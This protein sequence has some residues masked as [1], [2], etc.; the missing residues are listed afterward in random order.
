MLYLCANVFRTMFS[1]V[2]LDVLM[3]PKACLVRKKGGLPYGTDDSGGSKR[4]ETQTE[5]PF[6]RVSVLLRYV[7]ESLSRLSDREVVTPESFSFS[8]LPAKKNP[9]E[10][11]P[12]TELHAYIAWSS[13]F[14][15]KKAQQSNLLGLTH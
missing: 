4:M 2:F 10:G 8:R 12:P 15:C 6:L 13:F 11:T 7:F 9:S 3:L 14:S 5:D 1:N